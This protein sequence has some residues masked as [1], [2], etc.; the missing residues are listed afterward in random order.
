MARRTETSDP[1]VVVPA[2]PKQ[3]R[4]GRV[5][6]VVLIPI[7]IAAGGGAYLLVQSGSKPDHRQQ[8]AQ[9]AVQAYVTAWNSANFAAMAAHADVPARTISAIYSPMRTELLVTSARFTV[10]TVTRDQTGDRGTAPY[11]A[12]LVLSGFGAWRY[13]GSLPVVKTKSSTGQEVW[14]VHFTPAAIQPQLTAGETFARTHVSAARG[15]L[16]DS[17]GVPLRNADSDIDLN[18]LGTIGPLTAEQAKAAGPDFVAG[19]VAGQTGLERVY[20][21]QLAGDPGGAVVLMRGG[22]RVATLADYPAKAGRDIRT[23]LN[24]KVQQAGEAALSA[25]GYSAALVAIDTRTGGITAAVNHPVGG[26]PISIQGQYPPGSTFKVVTATAALLAGKTETSPINCP[27][28]YTVPGWTFKN[29]HNESFGLI[30]LRKAF[31]VSCNTAFVQIREAMTDAQMQKAVDLYGFDG[32]Q[33]LPIDSFGGSYPKQDGP[34]QAAA[35]A[36]GQSTVEA[37]PLQMAS[38]AAAVASGEWRRPF[39]VGPAKVVHTM[40]AAVASQM[41]DMMRAVVAEPEGTAYAVSFPGE[42]SG[43][44]GT[45]EYGSAPKGQDLPTHAWFIGFRGTVAFAVFVAGGGYGASVA[46]PIASNF[47]AQLGPA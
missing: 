13:S 47:L 19:D 32:E 40:P 15:Q 39:V 38:L 46:A 17:D 33:P 11:S 18:M 29:A 36:F 16:L 37:S 1:P 20:N 3:G 27:P 21:Q 44:T 26:A 10:G 30:D 45:A 31:E 23:T 42:V 9:A 14:R 24:L 41:R 34:V 4:I 43:K 35:A 5:L 28:T 12:R 2:T 7:L 22:Q 25:T 6:V 8:E